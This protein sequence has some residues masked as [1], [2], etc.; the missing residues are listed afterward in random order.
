[1]DAPLLCLVWAIT[2]LTAVFDVKLLFDGEFQQ[3]LIKIGVSGLHGGAVGGL[4]SAPILQQRH[5]VGRDCLVG[6]W[7]R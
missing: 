7:H 5:C 1:M 2:A 4:L 6:V 3:Y